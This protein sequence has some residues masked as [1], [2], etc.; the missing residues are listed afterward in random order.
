MSEPTSG[1]AGPTGAIHDIGYRHYDGPRLG[2]AYV[3]RSLYVDTL[4]GAFGL[5]RSGRSKV[6]PFL[7]LAV[8]SVPAIVM[9]IVTGYFGLAVD[10]A[11]QAVVACG[12][13]LFKYALSGDPLWTRE[14][15]GTALQ[16][17]AVGPDRAVLAAGDRKV[18]AGHTEA[19]LVKAAP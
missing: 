17:P 18:D 11:G 10:P 7:L 8:L 19:V 13:K 15:T 1:P 16:Q 2:P 6:M 14:L 3:R 5:G 4:R 12:A 9:G